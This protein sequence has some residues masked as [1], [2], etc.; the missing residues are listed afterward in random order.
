MS[1]LLPIEALELNL[2]AEYGYTSREFSK[3]P[4]VYV[5]DNYK[6]CLILAYHQMN[7]IE[8]RIKD[9]RNHFTLYRND[10]SIIIV[11]TETTFVHTDNDA[12]LIYDVITP[13]ENIANK[14]RSSF[15]NWDVSFDKITYSGKK[16]ET[17]VGYTLIGSGE[18]WFYDN[19]I[20]LNGISGYKR[21][22]Q[23]QSIFIYYELHVDHKITLPSNESLVSMPPVIEVVLKFGNEQQRQTMQPIV[24]GYQD[25]E[26]F[27][28]I[29]RIQH[30][31]E[32]LA[33]D[34]EVFTCTSD[35]MNDPIF[36]KLD[37]YLA[38]CINEL[39]KLDVSKDTKLRDARRIVIQ[40]AYKVIEELENKATGRTSS[41]QNLIKNRQSHHQQQQQQ[42]Q[43]PSQT[44]PQITAN[45]AT[46]AIPSF[47]S[48]NVQLPIN[49]AKR[50]IPSFNL[51]SV[52]SSF[53]PSIN[54]ASRPVIRQN[55][56][57][58]TK[59]VVNKSV[60]PSL[61]WFDARC[62]ELRDGNIDYFK[63]KN[64]ICASALKQKK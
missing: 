33:K 3:V 31:I 52:S 36:F 12:I 17:F 18:W 15:K 42:Q 56:V 8:N 45:F 44:Y 32:E 57:V 21:N 27:R 4:N 48:S 6:S 29:D 22:E 35:G 37:E 51:S 9:Y 19:G 34:V 24:S 47:N 41:N 64:F 2:N 63:P 28:T 49:Y 11:R 23:C 59:D 38:R 40:N 43:Q 62:Y 13:S 10:K 61:F 54:A 1:A 16:P 50:D 20:I 58:I 55:D 39:D 25:S 14:Y 5:S 60:M 53:L 7:K 46:Q 26:E 30:R